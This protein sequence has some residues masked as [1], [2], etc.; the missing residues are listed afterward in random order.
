MLQS[1]ID[2]R[3]VRFAERRD[4]DAI[5]G[6]LRELHGECGIRKGDGNP[7]RFCEDKVRSTVRSATDDQG[8]TGSFL[9]VIGDDPEGTVYLQVREQFY[10]DERILSEVWTFVSKPYRRSNNFKTLIAW[11][12]ALS[13]ALRAPLV[14]GVISSHRQDA[15]ARLIERQMKSKDVGR[16]FVF[17]FDQRDDEEDEE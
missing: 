14:M 6:M 7:L 4:E 15:K 2:P 10:T 17:N 9:G 11:S 1:A 16:Y 5:V 8:S 13:A 3:L 12:Q